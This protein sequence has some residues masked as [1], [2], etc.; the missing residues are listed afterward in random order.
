MAQTLYDGFVFGVLYALVA[1]G[2]VL[3]YRCTGV[4]NFAQGA[5]GT[6]AGYLAWHLTIVLGAPLPI[7]LIVAAAVGGILGVFIGGSISVLM[8]R[9]SALVQSVA[10]F[11]FAM[12]LQWLNRV[13]LGALPRRLDAP[14]GG[15]W[16]IVGV[17]VSSRDLTVLMVGAIVLLGVYCLVFK[18]NIGLKMRALSQ[19]RDTARIYGI[20]EWRIIAISWFCGSALAAI[21]GVLITTFIQIDHAI[22]VT[23]MNQSFGAMVLGGFGSIGGSFVGGIV[24]GIA[25]S[26]ITM[27]SS[28][29][30]KNTLILVFVLAILIF[31]PSGLLGVP[32]FRVAEGRESA[33][34]P[35]IPDGRHGFSLLGDIG[36]AIALVALLL[37]LAGLGFP[38]SRVTIGLLMST[39]IVVLGVSFIFYFQDRIPLGQGAFATLCVY[40]LH[41]TAVGWGLKLTIPWLIVAI[42][43]TGVVAAIIGWIT[44]RLD[45]FYFAVATLFLPLGIAELLGQMGPLT[46]G[47]A[48][49]NTPPVQG[50]FANSS[51][52]EQLLMLSAMLFAFVCGFVIVLLRTR[53]GKILVAIRDTPE[54]IEAVG[55]NP[56]PY[57]VLA[58]GISGAI[59]AL[60]GYMVAAE[61]SFVTP[62]D[63]GMHWSIL[64]LLA[65]FAG[66]SRFIIS[67]A[68]IGS[69][70]I[71]LV[72]ELVSR[73][74]GI[75]DMV[76]GIALI[77]TLM[78]PGSMRF[79]KSSAKVASAASPPRNSNLETVRATEG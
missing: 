72:P 19:D 48:G 4:L 39:A 34:G 6:T 14:F 77:A 49:I 59:A 66:G 9:K 30:L 33:L 47:T 50:I 26:T 15:E 21:S 7:A 42:G 23:L 44:L 35:P 29:D 65:T 31:R 24:L 2:I 16:K 28:S 64:L 38:I 63:F 25:S 57:R 62:E 36:M 78:M 56:V 68:I 52:P 58:F 76:L 71:V 74:G 18:T 75:S 32:K 40:F 46:N 22:A 41:I 5:I 8:P 11:G 13:I 3:I 69:A 12:V 54:A 67:G 37:L 51:T 53:L 17:F 20:S 60:G 43:F 45:G 55:I 1:I 61:L 70:V 27:F 79:R 73:L 10:T